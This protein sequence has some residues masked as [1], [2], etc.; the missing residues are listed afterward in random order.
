MSLARG[1]AV[2]VV[3]DVRLTGPGRTDPFGDELVDVHLGGA[4]PDGR[5]ILD[6]AP[7][8]ALPRRGAVLDGAGG[9]LV[10]G[11]WDH[12]VHTVQWALA[13]RRVEL[14]G[15]A[16]A[17]EAAARMAAS[18]VGDDGRRVGSGYRD[19][20]WSDVPT[21]ELL[22]AVTGDVPTYLINSD[23][24]SVWLNSAALRREG[25]TAADG[26]L[27]EEPAFEISR[28]LNALDVD[29]ADAAVDEA[30]RAAAARG[31]V[32]VVDLDMAWNAEAWDR[33][34]A[35]G[36][37]AVRISFGVYASSLQRAIAAG[38]QTGDAIDPAGLVR[39]GAF[40]VI[41]DGSLGTRTAACS[42]HYPGAASDFGIMT[43]PPGELRELM[44]R[45]TGAGIACA[46][47]AIGDVANT[48]ALDAFAA[49]GATGTIE[50]AQLVAHAD[51]PR[52]GRLGVAAS[53]QPSHAVDDR[54]M[55]EEYWSGQTS[56]AY[57]LRELADAGTN[58]LFG[59]DAPVAA[60][61]PWATIAAAVFRTRDDRQAWRP[62]QR[63]DAA[64]ALAASTAGGSDS[65][66]DLAPGDVAD[67]VVLDRDPLA[68][69][70]AAAM[71]G[72]RVAATLLAGR[73][74]HLA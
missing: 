41:T 59:S 51:L 23:V 14:D 26:I 73:L 63:I 54:D 29:L 22:D 42:H 32:G 10:P 65:G 45:A 55:A 49:T 56:V 53:V 2:D 11:L 74:T 72:T 21:L 18:D 6:I 68:A 66:S 20:L 17:G 4:H 58:L 47:H 9:W 36:F 48:H 40:K 50:H 70:S 43:V 3:A 69:G 67:L 12:H 52:F 46:V 25:M 5:A 35:R 64:T 61:D 27:R 60:L 13:S 33:R 44:Q 57:P 1:D 15:I 39:M 7:A 24:H 8:N 38:L 31:I 16:S 28:R 62:H 34:L 19:A 71:R 37:D 30:M